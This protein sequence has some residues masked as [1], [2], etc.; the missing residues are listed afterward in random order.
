MTDPERI[1]L[2]NIELF[3]KQLCTLKQ[4]FFD[5][6]HPIGEVYT[7]Y[8]QQDDPMTLYNKNGIT[9]V[10]EEQLQYN[11][12]FF[13][14]SNA[15]NVVWKID[16]ESNYYTIDN[17]NKVTPVKVKADTGGAI[18]IASSSSGHTKTI[19][20][21][22]YKDYA[23][24]G[25]STAAAAYINK[26]NNLNIQGNQNAYHRH[27]MAHTHD[28]SNH[29]HSLSSHTHTIN[30]G[31]SNTIAVNTATFSGNE[32]NGNLNDG[33]YGDGFPCTAATATGAFSSSVIDGNSGFSSGSG[34]RV[35]IIF[36]ATP[37]G[38]VSVTLKGGVTD[39]SGSSGGP[40][41]NTSGKPSNNTSGA[42]SNSDTTYNGS[43]TDTESRP[44]NY[45]Y[46]IWKRIA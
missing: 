16:G 14:S 2:K 23:V 1:D 26:T 15:L 19:S 38:K 31:H 28:L 20:G 39:H 35:K 3:G 43:S 12:A 18:N 33:S 29:T 45:S 24:T 9:S 40:S 21:K 44:N 6:I 5:A 32:I 34:A 17:T 10:W 37:T 36:K 11:G 25:Y 7:Q 30:H 42:A 46:I 22:T 27:S 41:N 13:R 4:D 8:P